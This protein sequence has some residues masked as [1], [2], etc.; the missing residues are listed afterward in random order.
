MA[1]ITPGLVAAAI[2]AA[3]ATASAAQSSANSQAANK[4]QARIAA[5]GLQNSVNQQQY[6]AALN[7]IAMKR[8]VAGTVDGRGD[9]TTYDPGTNTW[10]T[11]LSKQGKA[12]QNA[13]D[14]ATISRDTTDLTTA[15]D[16]NGMAMRRAIAAREAAGPALAAVRNYSP[17]TAGE[18]EGDLQQTATTANRQA[19]QPIIADTLRAF[20]RSGTAAGPVLTNMMRDNATSLRQTMLQD[21]IGAMKNVGDINTNN[22]TSLMGR[23]KGL[24][25]SA[26]P[27]LNF[28]PLATNSPND[29]LTQMMATR[30]AGA[31]QPASMGAYT[32]SAGTNATNNASQFSA[33]HPGVNNSG[34]Y[35]TL[36][37]SA[38]DRLLDKDSPFMKLF[39]GG[40][41]NAGDGLPSTAYLKTLNDQAN[42]NINNN[43]VN[44]I[45]GGNA[46]GM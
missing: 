30:A 35:G 19:Q 6:Q 31:A 7:A 17:L 21:K 23:Y 42:N 40:A 46:N 27:S 28:A 29:T 37:S 18:L 13:N 38:M 44:G 14:Q 9:T 26:N 25:Q 20:A 8:G 5:N 39:S 36:A 41:G 10:R 24:D 2:T 1:F 12:I 45:F 33:A 11:D 16:A 34:S 15:Q 43:T 3:A 32:A 22:L 4:T